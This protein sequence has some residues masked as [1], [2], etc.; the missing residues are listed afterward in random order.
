MLVHAQ[1]VSSGALQCEFY[2]FETRCDSCRSF[3]TPRILTTNSFLTPFVLRTQSLTGVPAWN[4]VGL[5]PLCLCCSTSY[6]YFWFHMVK[7]CSG[8]KTHRSCVFANISTDFF[9]DLLANVIHVPTKQWINV[10]PDINVVLSA[11]SVPQTNLQA[12]EWTCGSFLQ[13]VLPEFA[14]SFL[15]MWSDLWSFRKFVLIDWTVHL[16]YMCAS[17]SPVTQIC[18]RYRMRLHSLYTYKWKW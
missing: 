11:T 5:A 13:C 1:R 8:T 12:S 14:A 9:C 7:I 2:V 16:E 15:M 4:L 17:H 10:G 18:P 3:M 6:I